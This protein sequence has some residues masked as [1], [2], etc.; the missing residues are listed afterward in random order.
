MRRYSGIVWQRVWRSQ[1]PRALSTSTDATMFLKSLEECEIVSP[2]PGNS[3]TLSTVKDAARPQK[4]DPRSYKDEKVQAE[5]QRQR[6]LQRL[7]KDAQEEL[8]VLSQELFRGERSDALKKYKPGISAKIHMSSSEL[9]QDG[10]PQHLILRDESMMCSPKN[11]TKEELGS[12]KTECTDAAGS[13]AA[14]VSLVGT[15]VSNPECIQEKN[16]RVSCT[17]FHIEFAS[18]AFQGIMEGEECCGTV[19]AGVRCFGESFVLFAHENLVVG[20]TVHILGTLLP[21]SKECGY[22]IGVLPVGGNISIVLP[23]ARRK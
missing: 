9:I 19:R 21:C 15:I 16:A 7:I 5:L 1:R 14:V 18:S 20:D 3:E 23:S 22:I 6:T 17:Q 4:V 12:Q 13:A 2:N 11:K 8:N 10:S